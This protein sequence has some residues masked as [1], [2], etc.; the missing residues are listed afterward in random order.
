MSSRVDDFLSTMDDLG[1][2]VHADD[3]VQDS[4]MKIL[5]TMAKRVDK[6][7]DLA[8]A[9]ADR[10]MRLT[11]AVISLQDDVRNLEKRDE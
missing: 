3:N 8:S 9:N 2:E 7:I 11:D 4:N 1:Y 10:Q 6:L 5:M